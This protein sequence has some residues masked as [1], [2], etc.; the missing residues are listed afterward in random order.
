[1]NIMNVKN[2]NNL[3]ENKEDYNKIRNTSN[4]C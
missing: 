3:I 2:I 1:M 4:L